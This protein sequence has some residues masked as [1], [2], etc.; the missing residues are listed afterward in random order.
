[1]Q[2]DILE[3]KRDICG[4]TGEIQNKVCILLISIVP[5][6]VQSFDNYTMLIQNVNIRKINGF[7]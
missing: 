1:M 3:Q 6:L 4:K 5:M 7:T 2:C